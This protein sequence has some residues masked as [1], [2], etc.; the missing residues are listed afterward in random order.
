MRV[1]PA[2]TSGSEWNFKC[3]QTQTIEQEIHMFVEQLKN[4]HRKRRR[5]AAVSVKDD[6]VQVVLKRP[7]H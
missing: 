5:L 6:G 3:L 7:V 2:V 1:F 4:K